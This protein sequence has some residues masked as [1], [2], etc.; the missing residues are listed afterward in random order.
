MAEGRFLLSRTYRSLGKPATRASL[1]ILSRHNL[2]HSVYPHWKYQFNAGGVSLL[3]PRYHQAEPDLRALEQECFPA[4]RVWISVLGKCRSIGAGKASK[5]QLCWS[6]SRRCC[7]SI[8]QKAG[9]SEMT[10]AR[11]SLPQKWY[12]VWREKGYCRHF[13]MWPLQRIMLTLK[14]CIPTCSGKWLIALSLIPSAPMILDRYYQWYNEKSRH[15]SLNKKTP[16]AAN[17]PYVNPNPFENEKI[18]QLPSK[19]PQL[20]KD[21]YIAMA[22]NKQLQLSGKLPRTFT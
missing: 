12:L 13:L 2:S 7:L 20:I 21:R 18:T 15:N 3:K 5:K 9:A 10:R 8:K 16:G 19:N 14:P 11:S 4:I 1:P 22:V 6:Y 17:N